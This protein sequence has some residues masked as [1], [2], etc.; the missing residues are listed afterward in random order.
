[1]RFLDLRAAIRSLTQSPGFLTAAVLSLS[2]AIGASA[3]AFSVVDAVRFRTLPFPDG[4]RLVVLSERPE[5]REG[6]KSTV[7][8][9]TLVASLIPARRASRIDAAIAL[10]D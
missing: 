6:R 2:V 3:A 10:R 9:V 5:S 8:L 4:D 7:L 1:M